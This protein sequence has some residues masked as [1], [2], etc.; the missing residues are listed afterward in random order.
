MTKRIRQYLA[1]LTAVAVYYLIHEG[2]HFLYA[3]LTGT[4]KEIHFMGLGMQIDIHRELLT[5][6]QLGTFCL[7]GALATQA[8]TGSA[9]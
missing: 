2:A 6:T 4:F 5:D 9:I 7:V 3:I 8:A 1:L